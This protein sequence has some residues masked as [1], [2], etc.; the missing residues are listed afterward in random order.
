[1]SP[2]CPLSSTQ[3]AQLATQIKLWGQEL[4]FAAIGITDT[5]LSSHEPK[6]QAWLDQGY[7]GDMNYMAQHGMM[8]ARPHELHPGCVRVIS[9]RMDY[10][11]TN[12]RFTRELKEPMHGYI[13]RYAGGRDYHKLL[14]QRLKK[15][16]DKIAAELATFSEWHTDYRPF[17]DSAPILERPLAQKAG[18]GWTGKHTLLLSEEA[19]SWF[20]L[21]ELLINLPLP[22]DTPNQQDCGACTACI[23]SCP[24]GAIVAPF[25]VDA[26]RCISYLTIE[27][28]GPIA[29]HLRPLIGNRIYGC[30]DCQLVCPY[31]RAAPLSQEADFQT[32][33]VWQDTN[34]LS[35][36]AW[37]ETH[38]L[39]KTE[40]SPIRR[41][42]H[43]RWL[44]NISVALGNAPSHSDI[45]A[46]LKAKLELYQHDSMLLEHF[47]WA[48]TRQLQAEVNQDRKTAR[49]IRI[50]EKGLSRDA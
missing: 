27:L 4:G 7:H 20:F 50:I 30:D 19:G 35:L 34:L 48:L 29:E 17:V 13:S 32:R 15:L 42:G 24:T 47:T 23:T 5:D 45:I 49:L 44:R 33:D 31:N 18:L 12:A 21:G 25:T 37:D 38:F 22:I 36:F 10:L 14:R 41:I 9:A 40:G 46:A 43:R 2:A 1:M 39:A 3:L 28:D 6:L 16:G 8:R 26:R 11:P